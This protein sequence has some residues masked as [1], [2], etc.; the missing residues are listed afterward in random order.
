MPIQAG[1]GRAQR[2]RLKV[3]SEKRLLVRPFAVSRVLEV[4]L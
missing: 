2:E 3:D 4:S 1:L